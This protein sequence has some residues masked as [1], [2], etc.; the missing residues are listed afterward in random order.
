[1]STKKILGIT[2]FGLLLIAGALVVM[3]LSSTFRR[4]S[5]AIELPETPPIA[6]R[7]NGSATGALTRIDVN[8]DNIQ[9]VISTI[10]RPD[11][12]TRNIIVENFWE[13]GQ[14]TFYITVSVSGELTS[15]R[16]EPPTGQYRRIIVT[17][18]QLFIWN[19]GDQTPYIGTPDQIHA[20]HTIAD[21][22]QMLFTFENILDLNRNDI[23]DAGLT[24][25]EGN[26]CVFAL[27][28]SPFFGNSRKYYISIEDGLVIA[29]DEHDGAGALIYRMRAD[30]TLIGEIAYDAFVLPD[31][32]IIT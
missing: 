29:V 17:P 31:G 11:V 24:E 15:I 10:V 16:I 8:R 1:M 21:Q 9:S 7:P 27:Y 5:A 32:S 12:F 6:E 2:I 14:A 13:N 18:T 28:S 25:F 3:L 30:T 4:E 23:L 20:G 22:W 19:A 26:V